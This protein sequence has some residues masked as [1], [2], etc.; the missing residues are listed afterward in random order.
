MK[1][2]SFPYRLGARHVVVEVGYSPA[3]AA[4]H[5]G[6]DSPRFMD[7]GRPLEIRSVVVRWH[8]IDVTEEVS[9][10]QSLDIRSEARARLR[11]PASAA[12]LPLMQEARG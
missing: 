4:P 7:P 8:G 1:Y 6:A 12:P 5:A 2:L 3:K 9:V 11:S 10:V